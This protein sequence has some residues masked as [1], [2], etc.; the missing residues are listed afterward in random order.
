MKAGP[1]KALAAL[2]ILPALIGAAFALG[3]CDDV[4]VTSEPSKGGVVASP[5]QS[6]VDTRL[7][8][9]MQDAPW[10]VAYTGRRHVEQHWAIDSQGHDLEYYENV[11]ADGQ[12]R[13]A[14]SA[15]ELIYPVLSPGDAQVWTVLQESRQG[16][17]YRYRDFHVRDVTAFVR[18]YL[19]T[20]GVTGVQVAG[21]NCDEIVIRRKRGAHIVYTLSIDTETGLVLR[22]RQELLGGQLFELHEFE[23]I[24]LKAP[25]GIAWHEPSFPEQDLPPT[26]VDT[27]LGFEPK[28]PE[29]DGATFSRI[30][31]TMLDV[32]D[33]DNSGTTIRW[34]KHTLTDGVEAVFF[35]HGGPAPSSVN[36]DEMRVPPPIGPWN[37]I[38]G[39]LR[40]E[41]LMAVGRVSAPD[42]LDLM[43]EQL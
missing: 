28:L 11:A 13:F 29:D 15:P 20:P 30:A 35:L 37:V 25:E 3:G 8:R 22:N 27:L 19:I 39:S 42:L 4:S 1:S 5:L 41:R 17:N 2:R 14:I 40:G 31:G 18:N 34:A 6:G 26:G 32:P 38:E 12:G 23:T 33:P 10:K 16:F 36:G 43:A 9:K 7:L 24:E 21:R